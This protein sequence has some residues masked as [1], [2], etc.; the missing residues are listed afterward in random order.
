[1]YI[2]HRSYKRRKARAHVIHIRYLVTSIHLKLYVFPIIKKKKL[3][4]KELMSVSGEFIVLITN[5]FISIS[6]GR[7]FAHRV[8]CSLQSPARS[9]R[10]RN[11]RKLNTSVRESNPCGELYKTVRLIAP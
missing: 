9:S 4:Q 10:P 5:D 1:M 8:R 2:L 6:H 3:P 11:A 7:P